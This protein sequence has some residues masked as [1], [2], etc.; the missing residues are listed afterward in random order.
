[1]VLIAVA[2]MVK[3]AV[4]STV[5][6]SG[7]VKVALMECK[8]AVQKDYMMVDNKVGLLDS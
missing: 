6:M 7:A 8:S 1:M 3:N 5:D 2:E 4:D